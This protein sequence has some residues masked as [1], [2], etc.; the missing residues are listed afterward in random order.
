MERLPPTFSTSSRIERISHVECHEK[1]HPAGEMIMISSLLITC[2]T[3]KMA[4]IV[5]MMVSKLPFLS[6]TRQVTQLFR[7]QGKPEVRHALYMKSGQCRRSAFCTSLGVSGPRRG[8]DVTRSSAEKRSESLMCANSSAT[9]FSGE[10][11]RTNTIL[12]IIAPSFSITG[13][14]HVL[15]DPC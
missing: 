5:V 4:S 9:G 1:Y 15:K 7:K 11:K 2:V 6:L 8:N 14:I 13:C 10:G 12:S 3:S